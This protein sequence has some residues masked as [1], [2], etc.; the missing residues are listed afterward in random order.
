MMPNGDSEGW[1]FL[2]HPNTREALPWS[3][4]HAT[5]S[6]NEVFQHI[7]FCQN[8]CRDFHVRGNMLE[9]AFCNL[10]IRIYH[11]I[12]GGRD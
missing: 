8:K 9:V 1:I 7:S 3:R 5:G 2:S 4:K 12:E 10:F 11:D 6:L